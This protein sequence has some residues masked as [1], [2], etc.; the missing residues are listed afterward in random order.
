MK[1]FLLLGMAPMTAV[2][3]GFTLSIM[4]AWFVV[5]TFH[6]EQIRIPYAIGLAYIVQFLTHQTNSEETEPDTMR[7]LLEAILKPGVLLL[8]G[9]I[10]TWFV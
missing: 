10:V 3:Y 8:A 2:W 4:W 5:P 7:V 9:W 1:T 6:V